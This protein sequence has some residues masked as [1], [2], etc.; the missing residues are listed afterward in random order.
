MEETLVW[1]RWAAGAVML[2]GASV[3]DLRTRR[4]PNRYW[5]PFLVLAT[6]LWGVDLWQAPRAAAVGFLVAAISCGVFYALW[7]VGLLFGGAD[8]KALMVVAL[9]V[10]WNL[11]H[12]ATAVTP[13]FDALTDGLLGAMAVPL[14]LLAWNLGHGRWAGAA[15]FTAVPMPLVEARKRFVWPLERVTEDGALTRRHLQRRDEDLDA[16][17]GALEAATVQ[18]VWA[19]PKVPFLVPITVGYL[20]AAW[21]GNLILTWVQTL[22]G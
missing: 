12:A 10:P 14:G 6:V 17:Y 13:A 11:E 21:R 5:M 19:S 9:L 4:V 18:T 22:L 15:T 8:A 2:A 20:L 7:Y 16:V 1:I 3:S